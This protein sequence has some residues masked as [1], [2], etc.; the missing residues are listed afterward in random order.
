MVGEGVGIGGEKD[1]CYGS[2]GIWWFGFVYGLGLMWVCVFVVGF[3][4]YYVFVFEIWVDCPEG[5]DYVQLCPEGEL[6]A[7][8]VAAFREAF[9][10]LGEESRLIVNLGGV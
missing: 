7:Y 1:V 4:G 6:D 2:D 10:E 3:C 8:S 9:A 5:A